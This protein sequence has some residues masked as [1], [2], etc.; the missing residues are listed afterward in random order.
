MLNLKKLDRLCLCIV[1]AICVICGYWVAKQGTRQRQQIRRENDLL[2]R[3]LQDL[4]LTEINL[5]GLR[6]R[7][8]RVGADLRI[9]NEKVPQT[10]EIGLFLKNVD[11][12]MTSL[13]LVMINVQPFPAVREKLYSRIPVQLTFTGA[14]RDSYRLLWKLETMNRLLV[15]E[16]I[17]I[18]QPN[19]DEPCRVDLTANIFQRSE[20]VM[21]TAGKQP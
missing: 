12:L 14:F 17:N 3:K 9:L 7:L 16:K 5:Q 1:V 2:T 15:M 8:D 18:S 11:A 4:N 6:A 10:A 21:Q 19:I 13:N 20:P